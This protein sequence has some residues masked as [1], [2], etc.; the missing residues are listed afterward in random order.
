MA[1]GKRAQ[2]AISDDISYLMILTLAIIKM[3][4]E[5][6]PSEL[7]LA[8]EDDDLLNLFRMSI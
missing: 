8:E 2:D 3:I 5:L 1:R 6:S 7:K 4:R